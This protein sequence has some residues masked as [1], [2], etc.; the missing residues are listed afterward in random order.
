MKK[1][2]LA[3]LISLLTIAFAMPASAM[4]YFEP[5]PDLGIDF[6]ASIGLATEYDI[7]KY[8]DDQKDADPDLE[9]TSVLDFY[10]SSVFGMSAKS[11]NLYVKWEIG[12]ENYEDHSYSIYSRHLYGAYAFSDDL[13]LTIGQKF[14][15]SFWWTISAARSGYAG[16]GHGAMFDQR[17]PQIR[18]DIGPAYLIAEKTWTRSGI[19]GLD[20][21]STEVKLP[22]VYVGFDKK[23]DKHAVGA[24]IT[25]NAYNVT[26]E[27]TAGMN[28]DEETLAAW[29]AFVHGQV[30]VTD[31]V[32]L[33]S[34]VY[35]AQNAPQLGISS[36]EEEADALVNSDG[37]G[38]DNTK[39]I[40]GFLFA[41]A[42]MGKVKPF[43]GWGYASHD[44]DQYG[45]KDSSMEYYVGAVIDVWK[46]KY[47][48]ATIVPEIHVWDRLKD[49]N[50]N[51]EE[52]LT[53]IGAR[54]YVSF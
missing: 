37:D 48:N 51:E 34:Q 33:K 11:G 54:W 22:K 29:A 3:I 30:Q 20:N 13:K 35:Y 53:T 7:T 38:F 21:E 39:T 27:T 12:F 15:P 10:H 32:Y 24:G 14:N 1:L 9:D 45:E 5:T 50:D 2:L 43:A 36:I 49:R 16:M 46:H 6:Y 4:I 28:L 31:D 23:I 18:L 40:A 52:T 25:Y 41:Q 26:D 17:T 44:N 42:D 47:S 8:S 19:P